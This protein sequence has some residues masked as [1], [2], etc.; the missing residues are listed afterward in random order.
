MW[1]GKLKARRLRHERCAVAIQCLFRRHLATK[2]RK[3]LTLERYS[4]DRDRAARRIQ[5]AFRVLRH[6]NLVEI[7]P[8]IETT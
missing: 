3:A 8:R 6:K 4:R 2:L 5:Q 1:L 7:V